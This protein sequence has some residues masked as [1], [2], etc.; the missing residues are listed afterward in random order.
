MQVEPILI[1]S[2]LL[3]A[4]NRARYYWTNIT[5]ELPE[6]KNIKLLDVL[7]E[8]PKSSCELSEARLRWLL[9]DKGQECYIVTGKQIGRAHV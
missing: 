4:Q 7:D 3:S 8:I 6:S 9:S 5:V 1:N 2:N